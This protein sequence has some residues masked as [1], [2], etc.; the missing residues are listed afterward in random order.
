[1]L[2]HEFGTH[3]GIIIAAGSLL[4]EFPGDEA[5]R[6]AR[7][8]KIGAAVKPM[9]HL[10]DTLLVDVWFDTASAGPAM[11]SV[12]L[13]DLVAGVCDQWRKT[14]PGCQ[15]VQSCTAAARVVGDTNLLKVALDNL[16][17]NAIK[18]SPPGLPVA[19]GL[20][21]SDH[22][23]S[24][25]VAE[26]GSGIDRETCERLFEK[27]YRSPDAIP[28]A[29]TGPGLYLVRRI[30]TNHGG[31]ISAAPRPDGGSVFELRLPLAEAGGE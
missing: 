20:A 27:Y 15:I 22:W 21:V 17:D 19:V 29:G 2:S 12:D 18:Y 14:T 30:A 1:M 24:L 23:V 28:K 7:V 5:E 10:I 8:D 6:R 4:A 13:A 11:S 25:T 16:L 3:F 9:V 26:H 31:Q